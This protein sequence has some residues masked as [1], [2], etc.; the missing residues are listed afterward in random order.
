MN[1]HL[2]PLTDNCENP[3]AD[4]CTS[5]EVTID[6][7]KFLLNNKKK[8]HQSAASITSANRSAVEFKQIQTV[9][10]QNASG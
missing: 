4:G 7:V 1:K 8:A 9:P 10:L 2:K 3:S 6:N 5:A